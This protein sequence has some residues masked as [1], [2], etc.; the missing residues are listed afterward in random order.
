MVLMPE[1]FGNVERVFARNT[2]QVRCFNFCVDN[3]QSGKYKNSPYFKG[4]ILWDHLPDDVIA[5]P[6]LLEYK[7]DIK[8]RF[9]VFNE[10]ML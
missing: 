5:L 1:I 6:S 9:S 4:T 3:Y 2:R 7:K 8:L 10:D